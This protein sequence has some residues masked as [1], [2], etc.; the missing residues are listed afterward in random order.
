LASD[1]RP[2]LRAGWFRAAVGFASDD[3]IAVQARAVAA[4]LD[5]LRYAAHRHDGS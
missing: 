4:M 5:S 1:R 2:R 3:S